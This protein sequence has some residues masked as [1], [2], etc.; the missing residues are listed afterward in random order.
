VKT[1]WMF[2]ILAFFLA[3]CADQADE[4]PE[5]AEVTESPAAETSAVP[6]AEDPT[7]ESPDLATLA[8][9]DP[10][11][12]REAMR[13]PEQREALMQVMRERRRQGA[14]GRACMTGKKCANACASG[15]K[16]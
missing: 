9:T 3:A 13:D 7:D 15:A 5:P 4:A 1:T 16:S 12:L 11:A 14:E 2:A 8:R 10:E 6:V